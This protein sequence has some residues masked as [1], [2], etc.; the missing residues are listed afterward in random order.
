MLTGSETDEG[1]FWVGAIWK[2][3]VAAR[4]ELLRSGGEFG[5]GVGFMRSVVARVV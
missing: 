4:L 1:V 2:R 5:V 3:G